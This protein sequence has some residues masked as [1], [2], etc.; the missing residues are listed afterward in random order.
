MAGDCQSREGGVNR[1]SNFWK[2]S[3]AGQVEERSEG[4]E[5]NIRLFLE[6]DVFGL[7]NVE[8]ASVGMERLEAGHAF[9]VGEEV[10]VA[11]HDEQ[12]R[13]D[14]LHL[15]TGISISAGR[16]GVPADAVIIVA[17]QTKQAQARKDYM[18]PAPVDT[19]A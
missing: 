18:L 14:V 7:G 13:G 2:R 11:A 9:E 19:L 3:R 17:V 5:K 4:R 1:R 12:V 16:A 8:E 10:V 6:S 15:W